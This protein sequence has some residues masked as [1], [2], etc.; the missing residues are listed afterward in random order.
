MYKKISFAVFFV[1]FGFLPALVRAEGG[2]VINEIMYDSEGADIDWI[3]VYNAG[4][5]DIDLTSYKLLISNSTANHAIKAYSGSATLAPGGYGVIVVNSQISAFL[6]GWGSG[7]NLFTASFSLPNVTEDQTATVELNAGDKTAPVSS[8]TYE[9]LLGAG[10]DGNSL[11]LLDGSWKSYLPTPGGENV[12]DPGNAGEA[13][14]DGSGDSSGDS[15]DGSSS[16]V[17]KAPKIQAKIFFENPAFAGEPADFRGAILENSKEAAYYGRYVWNFGDGSTFFESGPAEKLS[18][19]YAYPGD[20]AVFLDYYN[21]IFSPAPDYSQR[22]AVKAVPVQISIKPA[23]GAK[24]FAVEIANASAYETDISG[25]RLAADGQTFAFPPNSVILPKKSLIISG[26][27][28]GF[29]PVAKNL[30]LISGTE[31]IIA[32]YQ[33]E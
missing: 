6:D 20:Y 33:P 26:R 2:P 1:L 3:E 16:A 13:G 19:I 8:V 18:H 17:P 25:W 30:K 9:A 7:G 28:T 5:A 15:G 14:S 23:G 22:I 31:E 12:F 4:S 10:G 32:S 24:D 21:S 11:Q 27:I 29:A